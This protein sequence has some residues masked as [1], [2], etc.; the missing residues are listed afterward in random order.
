MTPGARTATISSSTPE[1]PISPA[2]AA[3]ADTQRLVRESPELRYVALGDSF[4][5]GVG[6]EVTGHLVGWSDRVA[7]DLSGLRGGRTWYANLAVRGRKMDSIAGEQLDAALSLD[8]LPSIATICGGGNDMLN[9]LTWDLDRMLGHTQRAHRLCREAGVTLVIVTPAD[10]SPGLPGG[11]LVER[12]GDDL[13]R[14][15]RELAEQEGIPIV[16][17]SHDW[18]LRLTRYW[19]P[20]RLHLNA[21]GHQR[22]AASVLAT[23]A[24]TDPAPAPG[25]EVDPSRSGLAQ[26]RFAR[27]HLLPWVLRKVRG[28]SA[29]D[30][31]TA[32]FPGWVPLDAVA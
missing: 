13:A 25:D 8:P 11:R 2:A 31:R 4:S 20:D 1:A 27:E 6:D 17:V 3:L 5:E 29:G 7:T 24:G 14:A 19:S 12:R 9:L 21:L 16:D 22:V 15:H 30:G 32:K 26:V 23:I 28:R 18:V 10:P